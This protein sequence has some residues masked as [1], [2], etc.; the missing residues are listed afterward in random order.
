MSNVRGYKSIAAAFAAAKKLAKKTGRK[1]TVLVRREAQFKKNP[2]GYAGGYIIENARASIPYAMHVA[3]RSKI[4]S[5]ARQ[6]ALSAAMFFKRAKMQ[7]EFARK[8]RVWVGREKEFAVRQA[9]T[10]YGNGERSLARAEELRAG[11]R[12]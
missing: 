5:A 3:R 7:M 1:V 4:G 9:V 12:R 10:D 2:H 8:D 6:A 11:S